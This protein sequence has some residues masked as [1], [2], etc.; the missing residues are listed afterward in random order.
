MIPGDKIYCKRSYVNSSDTRFPKTHVTAGEYYKIIK[1]S[2]YE[3]ITGP[4]Y[5]T[6]QILTNGRIL[7]FY[8]KFPPQ[9]KIYFY[10]IQELRNLKL[11]RLCIK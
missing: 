3:K 4:N 6:Y 2:N 7:D 5:T 9:L 1:I 10:T 8:D 11:Q